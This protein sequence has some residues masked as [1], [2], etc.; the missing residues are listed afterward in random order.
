MTRDGVKTH[1]DQGE[2]NLPRYDGIPP[3]MGWEHQGIAAKFLCHVRTCLLGVR[4]LKSMIRP[5]VMELYTCWSADDLLYEGL[6]RT[7]VPKS[8]S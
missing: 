2:G 8:A 3:Q 1:I 5:R 4:Y 7:S 6:W